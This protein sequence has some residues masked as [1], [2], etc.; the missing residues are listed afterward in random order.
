MDPYCALLNANLRRDNP[1]HEKGR[2]GIH[3]Q[4]HVK[5]RKVDARLSLRYYLEK[6]LQDMGVSRIGAWATKG[7]A[8]NWLIV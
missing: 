6:L 3:M 8:S 5:E 2:L 1:P 4:E 7:L